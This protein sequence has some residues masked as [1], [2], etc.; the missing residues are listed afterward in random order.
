MTE[1]N[2]IECPHCGRVNMIHSGHDVESTPEDGDYSICWKCKLVS[3]YVMDGTLKLREPT[4]QEL[5]NLMKS[6]TEIQSAMHAMKESYYPSEALS[7]WR[8]N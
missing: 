7:L 4:E 3:V 2:P 1:E 8:K 5:I 6:D